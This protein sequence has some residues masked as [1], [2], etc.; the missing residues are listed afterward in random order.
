MTLFSIIIFL[1]IFSQWGLERRDF[2]L[3]KIN[4]SVNVHPQ[5]TNRNLTDVLF[6]W[7]SRRL[8][9]V[10]FLTLKMVYR[11]FGRGFWQWK[12]MV[13]SGL[14]ENQFSVIIAFVNM[15]VS[16]VSHWYVHRTHMVTIQ[17]SHP[18]VIISSQNRYPRTIIHGSNSLTGYPRRKS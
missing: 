6:I 15:G 3:S 11:Y 4:A 17:S 14:W 10:F 13:G 12:F 16:G 1:S 2:E 9:A 5:V 7:P 18:R 8:T